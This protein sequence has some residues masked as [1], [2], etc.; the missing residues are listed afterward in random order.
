[1]N[2]PGSFQLTYQHG[3]NTPD[4]LV[5]KNEMTAHRVFQ[6]PLNAVT[7]ATL[8]KDT[9]WNKLCCL[10]RLKPNFIWVNLN[11]DK[12]E[13]S[14]RKHSGLLRKLLSVYKHAKT[15]R[16]QECPHVPHPKAVPFQEWQL[17]NHTEYLGVASTSEMLQVQAG[18]PMSWPLFLL[19]S[20]HACWGNFIALDIPLAN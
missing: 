1:M 11:G 19:P 13:V 9:I 8:K 14:W 12:T 4:I 6:H 16:S 10:E 17:G 3:P 2:R 15:G 20:A 7:R 5:W 18:C